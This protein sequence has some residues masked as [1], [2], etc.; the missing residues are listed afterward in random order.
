M[1]SVLLGS[2]DVAV[3]ELLRLEPLVTTEI[4]N[5]T[6]YNTKSDEPL[7]GAGEWTLARVVHHV[8]VEAVLAFENRLAARM[9]A[10]VA[11]RSR[12]MLR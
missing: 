11:R 1:A 3:D 10:G 4:I 6:N 7:V 8:Q 2:L 9:S 5:I 12:R